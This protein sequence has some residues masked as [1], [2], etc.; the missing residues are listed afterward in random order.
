MNTMR[1]PNNTPESSE[2]TPNP[3][4]HWLGLLAKSVQKPATT[5][6]ASA[7]FL[8][9]LK[10]VTPADAKPNSPA[11]HPI[12]QRFAQL[13]QAGVSRDEAAAEIETHSLAKALSQRRVKMEA[14]VPKADE[15][16][17]AKLQQR[18]SDS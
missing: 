6:A 2:A 18:L 3:D 4:E 16:L 13:V 15:V 1:T 8:S 11:A 14:Q 17:F 12:S 10:R 5:N 7:A 9:K